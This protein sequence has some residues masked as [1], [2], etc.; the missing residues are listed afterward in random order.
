MDMIPQQQMGLAGTP[1]PGQM[2][3]PNGVQASDP[4]IGLL[5]K[6]LMDQKKKNVLTGQL[7]GTTKQS[8]GA[9]TAGADM[10]TGPQTQNTGSGP[11]L[12]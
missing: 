7:P 1:Q 9:G 4:Q 5:I 2:I 11:Q 6:A 8:L 10:A 12:A 3:G